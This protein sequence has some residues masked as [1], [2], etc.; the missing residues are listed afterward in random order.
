MCSTA[1]SAF[2]PSSRLRPS[3]FG[4][5]QEGQGGCWN[6]SRGPGSSA[7]SSCSRGSETGSAPQSS[8]SPQTP[9]E[10]RP[11]AIEEARWVR[12]EAQGRGLNGSV[13]CAPALR[14]EGPQQQQPPRQHPA[15]PASRT[16][17][18]ATWLRAGCVW[19]GVYF[20]LLYGVFWEYSPVFW[21]AVGSKPRRHLYNVWWIVELVYV[22]TTKIISYGRQTRWVGLKRRCHSEGCNTDRG[23]QAMVF[24]HKIQITPIH[25]DRTVDAIRPT[26][27]KQQSLLENCCEEM[28]ATLSG[29]PE[30]AEGRKAYSW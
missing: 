4:L 8:G 25:K 23:A 22:A 13:A 16:Q 6:P 27:V 29:E 7:S 15:R 21:A 28:S 24:S 5:Q 3:S 2:R 10:G 26:S 18:T 20:F 1:V 17:R 19:V 12:P 11:P 14:R 30:D 9:P